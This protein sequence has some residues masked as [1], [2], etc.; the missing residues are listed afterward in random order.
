MDTEPSPLYYMQAC[1]LYSV[2]YGAQALYCTYR[3]F[4]NYQRGLTVAQNGQVSVCS[5]AY[6][7]PNWQ[8]PNFT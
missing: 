7:P 4:V 1:A 2:R 8:A 5:L 6:T 3:N